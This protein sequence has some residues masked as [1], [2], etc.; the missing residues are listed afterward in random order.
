[1]KIFFFSPEIDLNFEDLETNSNA[2]TALKK[3]QG[4]YQDFYFNYSLEYD[5]RDSSF[6]PT[7]GSR[8]SFYQQLPLVSDNYELSILVTSRIDSSLEG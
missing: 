7:S 4:Q 8:T 6:R 3:Q 2:S 5:L 1:M